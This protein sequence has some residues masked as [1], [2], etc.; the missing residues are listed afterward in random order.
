MKNYREDFIDY[1]IVKT[2]K[3]M[4]LEKDGFRISISRIRLTME[5]IGK[6]CEEYVSDYLTE[7]KV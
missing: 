3:I 2:R 1:L 7:N 4:Q 6:F 5:D